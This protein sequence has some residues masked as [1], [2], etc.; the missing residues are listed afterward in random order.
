[1]KLAVDGLTPQ[2]RRVVELLVAGKRPR[3]IAL[4]MR[5]SDVTVRHYIQDVYDRLK[6][7]SRGELI[8]RALGGA[9]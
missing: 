7:H 8:A 2:Q 1:M 4:A 5:V 6:V 9:A 3:E